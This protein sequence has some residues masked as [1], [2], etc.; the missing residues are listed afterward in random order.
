MEVPVPSQGFGTMHQI[1]ASCA[2]KNSPR[3]FDGIPGQV[4]GMVGELQ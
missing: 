4:D 3:P 1:F 2:I